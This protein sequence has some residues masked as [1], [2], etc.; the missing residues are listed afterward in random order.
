MTSKRTAIVLGGSGSVGAALLRELFRDESFHAIL[1]LSRRSLPEAVELARATGRTL[2]EKLVPDMKPA[3]LA[4]AT[5][6]AAREVDGALEGFS[7]LGVGAGTAKLTLEEHRA[8]DVALN[9]AFARSLR[10]SG[11][12]QHL[13][14][15]SAVGADPT[16]KASGSGAAGMSRYNRVKGEAEEAVRASGP[17]VVSVFRPAMIIG[18]Q[19]TP[20]LL[21]KAL[22]FFS[23]VTPAKY[24]SISVQQIAKAMVASAKHHPA[25]SLT[26]HYPEMLALIANGQR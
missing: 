1:T 26:Y 20:W 9:E 11:K 7:V 8:V 3:T 10:D 23:V 5:L 21:E 18:S 6:E 4:A 2:V 25:T 13:A 12:A 22:P 16:A 19:H 24:K 14:F 17:A 15:M